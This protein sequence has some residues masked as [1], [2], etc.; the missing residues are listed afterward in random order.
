MVINWLYLLKEIFFFQEWHVSEELYYWGNTIGYWGYTFDIYKKTI[1][2]LDWKKQFKLGSI[3]TSV[4]ITHFS[5]LVYISSVFVPFHIS[6]HFEIKSI[7]L[8]RENIFQSNIRLSWM[9]ESGDLS[10]SQKKSSESHGHQ[11]APIIYQWKNFMLYIRS[12][13]FSNLDA[14]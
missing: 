10:S 14:E 13:R 8:A 5:S 4:V 7:N 1:E 6:F 2:N 12:A 11:D 9:V 3:Y